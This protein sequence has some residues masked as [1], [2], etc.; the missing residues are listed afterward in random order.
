MSVGRLDLLAEARAAR[1]LAGLT[2]EASLQLCTIGGARALG[3]AGET[4]SLSPGKWGD[5]VAIRPPAGTEHLAPEEQ[6]MASGPRDVLATFLG[7][8]DVHRGDRGR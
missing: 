4:G 6:V 5:C 3:I 1:R 8:R 7:G 2:A